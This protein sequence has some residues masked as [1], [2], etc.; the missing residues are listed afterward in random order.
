M[1]KAPTANQYELPIA[2]KAVETVVFNSP[3]HVGVYEGAIDFGTPVGTTV[4]AP[5]DGTVVAVMDEQQEYGSSSEYAHKANYVQIGHAESEISNLV[6]LEAGSAVVKEGDRIEQGQVVARTGLSGWMTDPHL[7]W[8]V[9][10]K[11]VSVT[12]FETLKIKLGEAAAELVLK[13]EMVIIPTVRE[14]LILRQLALP[15]DDE[16]YYEAVWE[17]PE[18]VDNYENTVSPKY[19]RIDD[20]RQA[21]L[22][23][24]NSLRMGIWDGEHFVGMIKAKVDEGKDAEVEIGYWLRASAVGNGHATLAVQALA[25]HVN[26]LYPRV[27]AVVHKDNQKSADVLTRSGFAPTYETEKEWGPA[28]VFEPA[29]K[30][31]LLPYAPKYQQRFASLVNDSHAEF[32]FPPNPTLDQDLAQPEAHFRNTWVIVNDDEVFG[33]VALKDS[34]NTGEVI[35]KRMYVRPEFRGQGFGKLLL[36]TAVAEVKE[37]GYKKITLDTNLKQ[38]DAQRIYETAGFKLGHKDGN[39]MFYELEVA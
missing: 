35:L 28:V 29:D 31:H 12:G 26:P 34:G 21:R 33:S 23:A 24:G 11:D 17:N 22:E 2:I 30:P 14:G 39:L 1:T 5:L 6:H 18:H 36:Q 3:A 10:R 27:F 32:G 9:I 25:A 37:A 16:A 8:D 13:K 4:L 7:H 20:V 15:S 19:T 38:A